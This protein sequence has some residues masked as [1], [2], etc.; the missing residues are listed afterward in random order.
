MAMQYIDAHRPSQ[1][2]RGGPEG[3]VALQYVDDGAFAEPWVG[4]RHWLASSLWEGV[5]EHGLGRKAVKLRKRGVEGGAET[6]VLLRGIDVRTV[7]ET[8]TLPVAKTI[9]ALEFLSSADF[10]PVMTRTPLKRV[11]ELRGS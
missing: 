6:R 10:D 7:R 8:L 2:R 5:L 3:F 9:R 1:C 4:L 11:R